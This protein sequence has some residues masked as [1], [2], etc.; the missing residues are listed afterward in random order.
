MENSHLEQLEN[1]IDR[2]Y[3]E[4]FNEEAK[5]VQS[6]IQLYNELY[7]SVTKES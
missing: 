5:A 7:E 3:R 6:L 2:L 1:A 4:G